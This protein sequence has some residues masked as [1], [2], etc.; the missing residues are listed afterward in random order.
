MFTYDTENLINS[1]NNYTQRKM[2][3][4][5]YCTGV[6]DIATN[7]WIIGFSIREQGA[8]LYDKLNIVSDLYFE[9]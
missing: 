5:L 3:K 4:T 8:K 7:R 2:D 6:P 9:N 1:V